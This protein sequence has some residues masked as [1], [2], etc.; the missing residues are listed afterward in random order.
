MVT[1]RVNVWFQPKLLTN[2][3][4]LVLCSIKEMS[5]RVRY[6]IEKEER[7]QEE[8]LLEDKDFVVDVVRVYVSLRN[9]LIIT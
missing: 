3:Y 9:V 2:L 7:L 8:Q 4:G 6:A 5:T 1:V